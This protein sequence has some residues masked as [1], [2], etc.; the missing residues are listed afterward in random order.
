MQCYEIRELCLTRYVVS[1]QTAPKPKARPSARKRGFLG[2]LRSYGQIAYSTYEEHPL[3]V[4]G[5]SAVL[6]LLAVA[7]PAVYLFA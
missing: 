3:V 6:G 2:T 1:V 4:G 7:A 5:V